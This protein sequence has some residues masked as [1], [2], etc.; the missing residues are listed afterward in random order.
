[1]IIRKHIGRVSDS[2]HTPFMTATA[3]NVYRPD[4]VHYGDPTINEDATNNS[5]AFKNDKYLLGET[6]INSMSILRSKWLLIVFIVFLFVIA[7]IRMR[8]SFFTDE[9]TYIK[10]FDEFAY[11]PDETLHPVPTVLPLP[12][13]QFEAQIPSQEDSLYSFGQVIIHLARTHNGKS[14]IWLSTIS[15]F[16]IYYPES[17]TWHQVP[18]R[19]EGTDLQVGTLFL[20]AD[21][22]VWGKTVI[23]HISNHIDRIPILSKFNEDRQDKATSFL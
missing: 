22:A 5:V 7:C 8:Q 1:M 6:R 18:R 10:P 23:N 12:P 20:N 2:F 19:I 9:T 14:E 21:G 3:V 16:L 17:Q 15:D 13:W 4:Q 11:L